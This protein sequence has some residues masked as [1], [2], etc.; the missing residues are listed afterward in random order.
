M[1]L[2]MVEYSDDAE[3]KRIVYAVEKWGE[4]LG[5]SK[6][7]G[8]TFFSEL[9]KKDFLL[10]ISQKLVPGIKLRLFKVEEQR[11]PGESI[12]ERTFSDGRLAFL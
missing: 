7:K 3:R 6:P 1:Y 5:I 11:I 10:E 4:K 9:I 2:I 12:E 8:M